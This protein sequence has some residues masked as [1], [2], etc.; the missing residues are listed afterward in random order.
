MM[1]EKGLKI[2]LNVELSYAGIDMPKV[3]SS[4]LRTLRDVTNITVKDINNN[5]HELTLEKG[6]PLA[7]VL[8]IL[9]FIA[10]RKV[11]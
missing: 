10:I 3:F 5:R 11:G 6:A 9:H 1:D 4:G 8:D 7:G 2:I